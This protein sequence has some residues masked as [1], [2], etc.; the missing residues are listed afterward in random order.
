[1]APDKSFKF[2]AVGIA[3]FVCLLLSVR[4]ILR[5]RGR[6]D[7]AEGQTRTSLNVSSSSFSNGALIPVRLTCE[8]DNLSPAVEFSSPPTGT[9]SIAIVMDDADSP[10]GFVHWLVYGIPS[11]V[12]AIAEGASSQKKLPSGAAE[13]LSY[14]AIS[15]YAGPCPPGKETHR[16]VIRVY[17]LGTSVS[18]PP[19]ITKQ[20]L[21][22]AVRG[23]V[24]AEGQWT[25]MYR[26]TGR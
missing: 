18:L 22:A 14:A 15:A 26:K 17:A 25:G 16:Y 3:I 21:A 2:T 11:G 23:Q 4:F 24:L 8:G 13:G 7:I 5:E 1:M 12:N 9:R 6:A 19:G 10:F 20:Q